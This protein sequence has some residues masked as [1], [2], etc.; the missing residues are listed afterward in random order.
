[1]FSYIG[2]ELVSGDTK[3]MIC[4]EG[5]PWGLHQFLYTNCDYIYC[6]L[7]FLAYILYVV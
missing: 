1:M 2:I 4:N 3:Y 6:M 7:A 5:K